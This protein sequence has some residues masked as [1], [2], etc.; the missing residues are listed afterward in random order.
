[1]KD[2]L[3]VRNLHGALQC[4]YAGVAYPRMPSTSSA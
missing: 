3:N 2:P 4:G 1:M